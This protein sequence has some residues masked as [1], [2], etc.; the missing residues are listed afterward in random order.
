MKS[1][2]SKNIARPGSKAAPKPLTRAGHM[3]AKMPKVAVPKVVRR[4]GRPSK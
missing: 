2:N 3:T 1:Y 4:M